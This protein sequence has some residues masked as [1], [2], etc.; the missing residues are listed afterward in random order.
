[1]RKWSVKY[2][3][4]SS[5]DVSMAVWKI[6]CLF[7][8]YAVWIYSIFFALT[9]VCLST[10]I[11]QTHSAVSFLLLIWS[12]MHKLFSYCI[13]LLRAPNSLEI[14]HLVY[15]T[16]SFFSS[17]YKICV[18][19][20]YCFFFIIKY[21]M[22]VLQLVLKCTLNTETHDTYLEWIMFSFA[23][24]VRVWIFVEPMHSI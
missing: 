15:G 4:R 23:L 16:D 5:F 20:F 19:H 2:G 13:F 10:S 1:M 11:S 18:V 6:V 8:F 3:W 12:I 21:N 9:I 14:V 7:A 24:D 17:S 22:Y